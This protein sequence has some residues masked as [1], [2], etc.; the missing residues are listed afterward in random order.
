MDQIKQYLRRNWLKVGLVA[1][2][3]FIAVKKDLSFKLHLNSPSP[4]EQIE[5]PA[6]PVEQPSKPTST[7]RFSDNMQQESVNDAAIA[8]FDFTPGTGN[9]KKLHAYD[10]LTQIEVTVI[11]KYIDRFDQVVINERQKFGIPSSIILANA[12]LHS[13]AGTNK[14]S[15]KQSNNHFAIPCTSDWR[16]ATD[17]YDSKCLR[18]YENAWTS[19]RDHSL[20]ITTGAFTGLTKY[21]STDYKNWAN[22]LEAN[23]FLKEP[24]LAKQLI[25]TIEKYELY[26]LDD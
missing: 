11:Q 14:W 10:Q 19:F 6:T 8:S 1:V 2:V 9:R 15:A 5:G 22:G 20:Y 21:S 12:L 17:N 26:R 7:E 18:V 16:G 24:E 25:R 13:Q 4:V 3:I 23:G